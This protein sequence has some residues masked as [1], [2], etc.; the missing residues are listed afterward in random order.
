V[1]AVIQYIPAGIWLAWSYLKG[2][3]IFVPILIHAAVNY[4]TI[5][6]IL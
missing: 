6:G 3:T 2:D 4:I 5:R 1:I